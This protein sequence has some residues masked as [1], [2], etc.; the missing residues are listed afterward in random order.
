MH[1]SS[2]DLYRAGTSPWHGLDARVKLSITLAYVLAVSLTPAGAWPAYVLFFTFVLA[3]SVASELGVRFAPQ[4][5]LLA[6]PFVLAALPLLATTP[7]RA[8]LSIPLGQRSLLL[9]FAGLERFLS[10]ACKS[11]LSL[12]MAVLLT[13]TTPMPDLLWAMRAL[14]L[15]ELLVSTVGL[16][17]RYLFVLADEAIRMLRAR[18][19]RSAAGE[20]A[21]SG[22]SVIWRARVTGSMAGS[23]FLRGY[24]R[25]ERIYNAMLARGY[26]GSIRSL[27]TKPLSAAHRL[28]LA[29]ALLVLSAL[30]LLGHLLS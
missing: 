19:A 5:A 11:W 10:I 1:A 13:A 30:V 27:P 14:H 7:G 24:E 29:T 4:R 18:E 21:H 15:P 6:F 22:G 2:L 17:W 23:L 26:D 9:T 12:Q 20:Q 25:S 28:T 3:A 16:M 8:F